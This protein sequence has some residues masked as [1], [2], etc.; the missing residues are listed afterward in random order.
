MRRAVIRIL[1][2]LLIGV[3]ITLLTAWACCALGKHRMFD[4]RR[5]GQLRADAYAE[6]DRL[7]QSAHKPHVDRYLARL[8]VSVGTCVLIIHETTSGASRW[9]EEQAAG[10]PMLA[11]AAEQI[12][13]GG[14]PSQIRWGARMGTMSLEFPPMPFRVAATAP[15]TAATAATTPMAPA[16]TANHLLP[17]RPL[18]GGLVINTGFFALAA[19]LLWML[20]IG[21]IHLQ[22]RLRG[23]CGHCAYPVGV[24]PVCSECGHKVLPRRA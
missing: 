24:S 13:E 4:A 20:A 22:R 11:L 7:G 9:R 6:E 17:L 1:T 2:F 15:T 18:W 3:L 16:M 23:R 5:L 10:W 21:A 19:W 8:F 14:K 12:V